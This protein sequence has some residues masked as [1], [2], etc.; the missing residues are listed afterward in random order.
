MIE[1]FIYRNWLTIFVILDQDCMHE[2]LSIRL[3]KMVCTKQEKVTTTLC[4]K[5]VFLILLFIFMQ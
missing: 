4:V 1:T 5:A 3:V 2:D